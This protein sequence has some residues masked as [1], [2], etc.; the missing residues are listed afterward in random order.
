M[1]TYKVTCDGICDFTAGEDEPSRLT[2]GVQIFRSSFPMTLVAYGSSG[3]DGFG[4]DHVAWTRTAVPAGK[5]VNLLVSEDAPSD[6]PLICDKAGG[7]LAAP[8]QTGPSGSDGRLEIDEMDQPTLSDLVRMRLEVELNGVLLFSFACARYKFIQA[9]VSW[10]ASKTG[11]TLEIETF[12]A[13]RWGRERRYRHYQEALV[14]GDRITIAARPL[15][16][17]GGSPEGQTA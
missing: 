14:V 10:N 7:E 13:R 9:G 4:M 8:V 3:W 11:P 1:Y 5:E 6:L 15:D 17:L 16:R 12:L 2:A